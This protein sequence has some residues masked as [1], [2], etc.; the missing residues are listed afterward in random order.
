VSP[1]GRYIFYL[2]GYHGAGKSSLAQYLAESHR[3]PFIETGA[4][5]RSQYQRDQAVMQ[6][7]DLDDYIEQTERRQPLYF[8]YRLRDAVAG[9]LGDPS[10]PAV[11]LNG[12]RGTLFLNQLQ[13][14]LP[15]C[16]HV[17][18]WIDHASTDV[19]RQRCSCREGTPI[20]EDEFASLLEADRRL[21]IDSL[22]VHAQRYIRNEGSLADFHRQGDLLVRE[23]VTLEARL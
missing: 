3:I 13:Q 7:L 8:A 16:H 23:V 15:D 11:I 1:V 17:V 20:S 12:L 2:A 19:L 5:V 4:F 9:M 14:I 21:G 6:R 10:I 22:R 18:I